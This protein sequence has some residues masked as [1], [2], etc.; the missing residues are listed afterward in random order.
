MELVR[1][2]KIT[3]YCDQQK[4]STRQRLDLFIQVCQ[5]VQHAHQKGII[6]R[7]LKPSNIL[8]TEQDGAPMPKIIDFGIAKATGEQRLTDKTLFTAFEQFIGT[9]AYMSPEQAGLGGLDIDTRSDIYS[10]GVLLYELLTGQAPFDAEQL[11]RSALDEVLRTIREQEPPRPSTRLTTLSEQELTTVAQRRQ[12]EASKLPNLVRGDLDWI[13]MKAMDKDRRRRYDTANGLARDIE[14]VVA[15]EPVVARPPSNL[16]RFQK[17]VRRNKIV[18]T[19]GALVVVSL[20]AGLVVSTWMFAKE[21]K[22]RQRALAAEDTARKKEAEAEAASA[23]FQKS[24]RE[25][26]R[27][28]YV[29]EMGLARAAWEQGQLER[30]RELLRSHIPKAGEEDLRGFEW[31]Y[32]WRLCREDA[33]ATL[34]GHADYVQCIA[35]S[36]DA[37]LLAAGLGNGEVKLWDVVN[38]REVGTLPPPDVPRKEVRSVVFSPDGRTLAVAHFS[39]HL[40]LWD[41][42]TRRVVKSIGEVAPMEKMLRFLNDGRVLACATTDGAIGLWDVGSGALVGRMEGSG[43]PRPAIAIS[44]DGTTLASSSGDRDILLWDLTTRRRLAI[45]QGHTAKVNSMQFS[46]DGA[47]LAS[48]SADCA[49]RLWDVAQRREVALLSGHRVEPYSVS[50]SSDGRTLASTSVEGLIKLWDVASRAELRTLRGHIAMVNAALFFADDEI[51]VT[52]SDDRTIKL[53]HVASPPASAML[54][55]LGG[56]AAEARFLPDGKSLVIR[57]TDGTLTF[58]DPATGKQTAQLT[59]NFKGLS[60]TGQIGVGQWQT[61]ELEFWDTVAPR[62]IAATGSFHG[63]LDKEVFSPDDHFFACTDG[64]G[65][66][67]LWDVA[68]GRLQGTLRGPTNSTTPVEELWFPGGTG[69][70]VLGIQRSTNVFRFWDPATDQED[71]ALPK[72][73]R[74]LRR[75]LDN[76]VSLSVL[77]D[78]GGQAVIES[79]TLP[80]TGPLRLLSLLALPDGKRVLTGGERDIELWD[81][82]TGHLLARLKG[83][84]GWVSGLALSADGRTLV[85]SANDGTLKLWSMQLGKELLAFPGDV[86]AWSKVAISSDGNSIVALS[87]D[88]DRLVR[89]IHAPSLQVIKEAEARQVTVASEP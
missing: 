87:P 56:S 89:V 85:S 83:H 62:L 28:L 14:R 15:N 51:L 6:H 44:P 31:R 40:R 88:K 27:N 16:Y 54:K 36:P 32:L 82:T 5:A 78:D 17:L 67:R 29:A 43:T 76:H 37:R 34:A 46:P 57:A 74:R 64:E 20:M 77:Y 68:T 48:S 59:G 22:A 26:H 7:D 3:S 81:L 52:A 41:V 55:G 79:R 23:E 60:S 35:L 58:W 70:L 71:E 49:V 18:V 63:S 25:K 50:F 86:S 45:L 75:T 73:V 21:R 33:L 38:R 80:A 53:W 8:V 47:L 1:G 4:L 12:T 24:E 19:T 2:V 42:T 11:S 69:G 84:G 13:V 66:V 72:N 65:T 39:T 30:M 9:P 61:G 10:L